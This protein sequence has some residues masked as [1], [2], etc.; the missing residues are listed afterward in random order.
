MFIVVGSGPAG[1]AC[2]KALLDQGATVTMLDA[3]LTLE[4]EKERVIAPLLTQRPEEWSDEAL[5]LLRS[6]VT[7]RASGVQVKFAYG[8]D[9]P[10]QIAERDLGIERQNVGCVP[11]FARG[12]MSNVWGGSILSYRDDDLPDWPIGTTELA[13]HYRAVLGWVA[14]SSVKDRLEGT[15]PTYSACA[16]SIP[17]SRQAVEL[18]ADMETS[19]DRLQQQG[20]VF[21]QSR[22]A[23]D[24]ACIRCGLCMYGCPKYFIF[25]AATI[26]ARLVSHPRFSYRPGVLVDGVRESGDEVTLL[27][28]ALHGGERTEMRAVRVFLGC[29]PLSTTRIMLSSLEAFD[30]EVVMHDSQHYLLPFLRY[31]TTRGFDSEPTH[32][33]AQV[34]VEIFDRE[35]SPYSL[36]LQLYS[37]NDLYLRV[38]EGM[39]GPLTRA[40]RCARYSAGCGSRRDTCTRPNHQASAPPSR[41]R[42]ATVGRGCGCVPPAPVTP[43]RR[44]AGSC[45]SCGRS[46]VSF[47]WCPSRPC[48]RS[49]APEQATMWAAPFPCVPM[50]G[51]SRATRSVGPTGSREFTS[52]TRRP[53]RAF[54]RAR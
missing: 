15:F 36:H 25:N 48:S 12:G 30:R 13:P 11:S 44:C 10:Y 1:I 23:V 53:S 47:A 18:L 28:R 46:D 35:V 2:A 26:L 33:L 51:P 17:P 24:P 32:S 49:P 50:P 19:A 21:G 42:S 31:H 27:T 41:S 54:L 8:S 7:P 29:G 6:G 40:M 9:Y 52:S 22:L 45:A 20:V 3:G 4:P 14:H 38:F 5:T 43:R 16:A 37:Y 34:F 39:F